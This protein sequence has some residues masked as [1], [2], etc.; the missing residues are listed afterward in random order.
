[1]TTLKYR[2]ARI[3]CTLMGVPGLARKDVNLQVQE[4][5][6]HGGI[7]SSPDKSFGKEKW[8]TKHL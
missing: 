2:A 1:M 3:V 5:I 8:P 7:S 4:Y 6:Y